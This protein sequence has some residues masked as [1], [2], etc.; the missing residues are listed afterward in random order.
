MGSAE[1]E[2]AVQGARRD[3]EQQCALQKVLLTI[4]L[5]K[6]WEKIT[7]D[8]FD[9]LHASLVHIITDG[10]NAILQEL[11][12]NN[13]INTLSPLSNEEAPL[14]SVEV[15]LTQAPTPILQNKIITLQR[16]E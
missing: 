14:S 10:N 4:E 5:D 11:A 16:G 1:K 3:S 8:N 13:K 15:L 2:E 12:E 7:S 9:K 6:V